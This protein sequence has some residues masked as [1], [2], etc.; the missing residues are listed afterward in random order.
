MLKRWHSVG[1]VILVAAI[2]KK[3]IASVRGV[4]VEASGQHSP[5]FDIEILQ[6]GLSGAAMRDTVR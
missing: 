6:E 4:R 2:E 3:S 5:N 1:V